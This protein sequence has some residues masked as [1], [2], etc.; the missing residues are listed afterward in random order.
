MQAEFSPPTPPP[1]HTQTHTYLTHHPWSVQAP[2]YPP[3]GQLNGMQPPRGPPMP[4]RGYMQP[5]GPHQHPQHHQQ[6]QQQQ[7]EMPLLMK[8]R[9]QGS[10]HMSPE[11]IE[12]I[13]RLQW[14][15]LHG[16]SPYH[17]DY[18]YQVHR[19]ESCPCMLT[20]S[21][22]MQKLHRPMH[23]ALDMPMHAG[24]GCTATSHHGRQDG[25]KGVC[26]QGDRSA[27]HVNTHTCSMPMQALMADLVGAS[28]P[29]W[30]QGAPPAH[31]T[32]TY[33]FD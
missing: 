9:L 7:Q 3:P 22:S 5:L 29:I 31:N 32:S 8:R 30:P 4:P 16:A 23:N 27:H 17:E 24:A 26:P 21:T 14:K 15:S 2:A 18:Y 25:G 20:G 33:A 1:T 10:Q 13:L 19:L 12:S 6:Q 11:E 28:V